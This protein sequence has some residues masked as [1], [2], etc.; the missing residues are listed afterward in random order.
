MSMGILPLYGA[1]S[2][3]ATSTSITSTLAELRNYPNITQQYA[4]YV[5][6]DFNYWWNSTSANNNAQW[7]T[8]STGTGAASSI[9]NPGTHTAQTGLLAMT[10]GSTS[11]GNNTMYAGYQ[12]NWMSGLGDKG[13]VRYNVAVETLATSAN[14]FVVQL[15]LINANSIDNGG[16]F[17]DYSLSS[18]NWRYVGSTS[19]GKLKIDSGVPVVAG[20]YYDLGFTLDKNAIANYYID[21]NLVGTLDTI[22][23][24]ASGYAIGL[25]IV[26]TAG[27]TASRLLV[28]WVYGWL[29]NATRINY[30]IPEP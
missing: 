25:K 23:T 21:G 15:G 22:P 19:G 9:I 20:H 30:Y 28:D 7:C 13:M 8:N 12:F 1:G 3:G 11:A 4:V 14:N 5:F 24:S 27:T 18:P 10:T 26:K 6:D 17:F 29:K 2:G 16:Q